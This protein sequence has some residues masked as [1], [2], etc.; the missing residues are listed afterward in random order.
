VPGG[1][2]AFGVRSAS[3]GPGS[4]FTLPNISFGRTFSR[5]D[6]SDGAAKCVVSNQHQY[7]ATY[8]DE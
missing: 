6:W 4:R 2:R 8:R 1:Q 5:W 7:R 3:K